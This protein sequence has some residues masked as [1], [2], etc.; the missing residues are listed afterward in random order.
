MNACGYVPPKYNSYPYIE[1]FT[2]QENICV[3]NRIPRPAEQLKT[4]E[5][6]MKD[7]NDAN[8]YHVP[9][10]YHR[11]LGLEYVYSHFKTLLL[12]STLIPGIN[13]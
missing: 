11:F 6:I 1:T 13:Y 9:A 4:V 2:H 3:F 5:Q 10:R 12:F 8:L 7:E